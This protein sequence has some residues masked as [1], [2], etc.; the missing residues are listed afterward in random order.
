MKQI[1]GFIVVFLVMLCP[2]QG[3]ATHL[4]GGEMTYTYIST[5]GSGWHTYEVR[6]AIYRDCSSANSNGTDFDGIA[7]LGVYLNGSLV[8]NL[9]STLDESLIE[10]ILPQDPNSCAELPDD[11]CIERGEYIFNVTLAPNSDSYVLSYQRCCRSPAIVNLDIPEDQGFTLTTEI[12]GSA[13]VDQPNSSPSFSELPQA[14]VC[15]NLEFDLNNSAMDPDGDSLAYHI[16]AI[17]LGATPLQPIPSP[18][19]G[20]PFTEVSWAMGYNSAVPVSSLSGISIDAQTGMLSGTPLG[21]GKYAIGV[22]VEEWR[23]GILINSILRDFTLDVVNCALSAPSYE[24]IEP[25]QGLVV[26]FNQTGNTAES[27]DWNFGFP[28]ADGSSTAEEPTVSFPEPGIY[29]VNLSYMS[30]DCSGETSFL[31]QAQSPWEVEVDLGEPECINGGWLVPVNSPLGLP[32]SCS[33]QWDFGVGAVPAGAQNETPEEVWFPSGSTSV[34]EFVSESFGC[35]ET[36]ELG[37]DLAPL[38][39]ADFQVITPP[40]RGLTVEFVNSDPTPWP[41]SW[42]FGDGE[43]GTGPNPVH[44][45]GDYGPYTISAIAGP[46]TTCADTAWQSFS[47]YPLDPFE[48]NFDVNPI[49]SC[50]SLSR[51]QITYLGLPADELTWSFPEQGDLSDSP[52]VLLFE[53]PGFYT[54]IVSLYHEGC[55]LTFDFP[56]D[57]EAP[58][59]IAEVDYRVPNVFSPNNDGKNDRLAL[60]Y[61]AL[62]GNPVTGLTNTSFL[63]HHLAV[64]NRW[65]NLM[66]ETGEALKGWWASDAAEGTYYIVVRSQHACSDSPFEYQGEV[67]LVR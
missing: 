18:P 51:V 67:T 6:V 17:Y 55:D 20:S 27:Y 58:E 16:C 61:F 37:V 59:P 24:A 30:G 66:F 4:M 47:V 50:D 5:N 32:D 52:I 56:L 33:Y 40:C 42:S 35:I 19:L 43:S 28:G 21:L 38:P 62:D 65:G 26:S 57:V 7:N 22:C 11:L 14:F 45:Y 54:G 53:D 13:L 49:A 15:N 63:S 2:I 25:C 3:W 34:V 31:I 8:S 46:G 48:P 41:F 44:V 60:D 12:P 9:S 10:N 36:S 39:I 64:Y 1:V 29:E 23:Q